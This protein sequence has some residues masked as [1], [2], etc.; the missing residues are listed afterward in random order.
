MAVITIPFDYDPQR[1]GESVIPIYLNDTDENGETIFFGWI[2]VV[3]RIQDKLRALSRAI[4][5]DVWRVSEL[6]D[7]TVHRLWRKYRDN[8]GRD[9]GFRVYVTARRIAHS[10]EDPGARVHLAL[11]ISLDALEEYRKYAV[12]DV[13]KT[14]R[15][16]CTNLDLQRFETKLKELGK[17]NDLDVYRMLKAGYYWHEIGQRVGERPNTVYRRFRRLLRRIVGL[18]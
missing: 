9:P 15:A 6:T 16:Y 8:L 5:G 1:D 14:E 12:G 11:N 3:V 18:T 13:N 10:L 2:E 17:K 4:L 7:L